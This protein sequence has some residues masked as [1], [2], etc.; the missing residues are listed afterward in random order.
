MFV[1]DLNEKRIISDKEL[2]ATDLHFST[3]G[4]WVAKTI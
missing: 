3:Y 4:E 2:K 1:I